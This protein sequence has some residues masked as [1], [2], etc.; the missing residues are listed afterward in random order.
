MKVLKILLLLFFIVALF[1]SCSS[2]A[3]FTGSTDSKTISK[4]YSSAGVITGIAS[5]Y[6]DEYH[7][8]K[9][10][11]GEVFDMNKLTA[12]HYDLPFNTM[13]KVTNIKNNKSVVVRVNDRMPSFKNR[14]IDL[15]YGAAK[16]LDMIQDGIVEVKI[17][18]IE[19]RK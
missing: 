15:S 11:N 13:L 4:K 12:A 3:R 6:A 19:I 2:T 7:G 14:V 1:I 17:E 5:Y 18:I 9:T 8:N 10:A 16:E